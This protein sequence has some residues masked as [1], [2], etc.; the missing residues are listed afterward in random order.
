MAHQS[1]TTTEYGSGPGGQAGQATMSGGGQM[2]GMS[3]GQQG[4][5]GQVGNLQ[6]AEQ[7][8]MRLGDEVMRPLPIGSHG[9]V[10]PEE[11]RQ[12]LAHH[13]QALVQAAAALIKD[14]NDGKSRAELDQH[15][16]GLALNLQELIATARQAA[17]ASGGDVSLLDAAKAV[18]EALRN[19]MAMAGEHADHPSPESRAKLAEAAALLQAT[20]AALSA[21]SAHNL[22]DDPSRNLLLESARA[23]AA[24]VD[25]LMST[26]SSAAYANPAAQQKAQEA[27][28]KLGNAQQRVVRTSKAVAPVI[29]DD[30]CKKYM[31]GSAKA[32]S[33]ATQFLVSQTA[34]DIKDPAAR[35]ELQKAA[36]AVNEALKQ[37]LSSSECAASESQAGRESMAA[38][39]FLIQDAV[40]KLM[41]SEGDREMIV[42]ASRATAQASAQLVTAAKAV[43]ANSSP[44]ERQR[45]L[46]GVTGVATATKEMLR[47]ANPAA[48]DPNNAEAHKELR[49]SAQKVSDAAKAILGDMTTKEASVCALRSAAKAVAACTSGLIADSKTACGKTDN[50]ETRRKL[51]SAAD[52]AGGATQELVRAVKESWEHPG[53]EAYENQLIQAATQSSRPNQ[54]LVATARAS[55]PRVKDLQ[56]KAD[57]NTSA[58]STGD[59]IK[60]MM[61]CIRDLK[62]AGGHME[63]DEALERYH[64]SLADLEF[65]ILSAS[66]GNFQAVPGATREGAMELL[67]IACRSLQQAS[68]E[69]ANK[70]QVSPKAMGPP[71]RAT[72]DAVDQVMSAAKG[73]ASTTDSRATQVKILEAAR[74]VGGETE[75]L[76]QAGRALSINTNDPGLHKNVGKARDGVN[77]AIEELLAA[78]SNA[79]AGAGECEKAAKEVLQQA[80]IELTGV[81][82]SGD[83]LQDIADDL[84]S[85]CRALESAAQQAAVSA[86]TN[87]KNL[88]PAANLTSSTM[89]PILRYYCLME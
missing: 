69:L 65:Q 86:R 3:P 45:L 51:H 53:D 36:Q 71:A 13:N 10:S 63:V 61:D 18:S 44:Q 72:T 38:A 85:A 2:S 66:Q 57:L 56:L 50:A 12:T 77:L 1:I 14:A 15:A 30:S 75:R 54:G 46:E 33:D 24:A 60:R 59:A 62:E 67:E 11:L 8:A 58:V 6:D 16:P 73:L 79:G 42:S 27:R 39:A 74:D 22:A 47:S 49:D 26:S 9:E 4:L 17:V 41:S 32:L 82:G 31:A 34:S 40:A 80:Q 84:A 64:A 78:A 81:G 5:A 28:D 76:V 25:D 68:G 37:L 7:A 43:A 89:P 35:D 21:T 29:V 23:V 88:G 48:N 70:S 55:A 52:E 20:S 19:M 87:P 83:D